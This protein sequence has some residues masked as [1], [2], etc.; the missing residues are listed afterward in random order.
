MRTEMFTGASHLLA[1]HGERH[2]RTTEQMTRFDSGLREAL[3]GLEPP[4]MA[5][6]GEGLNRRW[7]M[8]ANG[9]RSKLAAIYPAEQVSVVGQ[10]CRQRRRSSRAASGL[11]PEPLYTHDSDVSVEQSVICPAGSGLGA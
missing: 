11:K 9:R 10:E 3:R 4:S 2:G 1:R 8:A 6:R 5:V 7:C